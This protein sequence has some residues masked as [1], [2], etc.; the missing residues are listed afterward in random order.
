MD[1]AKLIQSGNL[2]PQSQQALMAALAIMSHRARTAGVNPQQLAT[3]SGIPEMSGLPNADYQM[4]PSSIASMVSRRD[5]AQ[6][7]QDKLP[8]IDN[9]TATPLLNSGSGQLVKSQL[10]RGGTDAENILRYVNNKKQF[11]WGAR[12]QRPGGVEATYGDIQPVTSAD[13]LLTNPAFQSIARADPAR[14]AKTYKALTGQDWTQDMVD[15][16]KQQDT[17]QKGWDEGLQK[18]FMEGTLR[19]HPTMG[20][21]ERRRTIPNIDPTAPPTDF[22]EPADA[23]VQQADAKYGQEGTG[24]ARPPMASLLDGVHP[25][26]INSFLQE[27]YNQKKAGKTEREAI[28]SANSLINSQIT[29][30]AQIATLQ[31]VPAA[32]KVPPTPQPVGPSAATAYP[33]QATAEAVKK[34]AGVATDFLWNKAMPGLLNVPVAAANIGAAIPNAATAA[35]NTVGALFGAKSRV[36]QPLPWTPAVTDAT[37]FRDDLGYLLTPADMVDQRN[38]E[39]GFPTQM[40]TLPPEKTPPDDSGFF[41]MY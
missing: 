26:Q 25:A 3:A 23:T 8:T 38:K 39:A 28:T 31:N 36:A 18:G 20:W 15:K 4:S 21:L 5:A 40:N 13:Q 1:I 2:D 22:W 27:F 30:P 9:F 24:F 29:T 32:A 16:K 17:M 7:K 12:F 14:A 11:D 19:R 37:K 35:V 10:A 33:E 34:T 6:A 41:S